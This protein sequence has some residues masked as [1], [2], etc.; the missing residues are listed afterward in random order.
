MTIKDWFHSYTMENGAVENEIQFLHGGVENAT[1][2]IQNNG[3]VV[4]PHKIKP[5]TH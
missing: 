1:L 4:S 5:N 2:P 3:E